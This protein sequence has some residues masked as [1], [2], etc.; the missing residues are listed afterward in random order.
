[1]LQLTF[2]T[3]RAEDKARVAIGSLLMAVLMFF[4]WKHAFVRWGNHHDKFFSLFPA[5]ALASAVL[6]PKAE[7][8]TIFSTS[9]ILLALLSALVGMEISEQSGYITFLQTLARYYKP[10]LLHGI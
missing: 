3:F 9:L 8:S 5:I 4:L 1:M 2:Y 7:R 10:W 6:R